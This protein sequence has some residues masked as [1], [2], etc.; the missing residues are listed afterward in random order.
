[1]LPNTVVRLED[2]TPIAWAFMGEL[3]FIRIVQPTTDACP[4][5]LDG[6]I[7]TLH[8]EVSV[9]LLRRWDSQVHKILGTI[10]PTRHCKGTGL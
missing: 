5:G 1:M 8:V 3:E 7:I 9:E 2:G 10:P 6:T 4:A